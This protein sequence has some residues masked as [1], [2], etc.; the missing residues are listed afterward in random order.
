M[1]RGSR[2]FAL[3]TLLLIVGVVALALRAA[4]EQGPEALK[5]M[6][7]ALAKPVLVTLG[8]FGLLRAFL[9]RILLALGAGTAGVAAAPWLAAA[10]ALAALWSFASVRLVAQQAGVSMPGGSSRGS[11]CP[12][13]HVPGVDTSTGR[14]VCVPRT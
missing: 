4:K 8:A 12:P 6:L 10:G 7:S 14:F 11:T 2:S 13:G 9:P 5:D 1:K 3:F